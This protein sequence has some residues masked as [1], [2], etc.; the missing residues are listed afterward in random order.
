MDI[1]ER[2]AGKQDGP[3]K[4]I[5]GP[6]NS[7]RFTF[8]HIM[9]HISQQLVNCFHA[10]HILS[11]EKLQIYQKFGALGYDLIL[12]PSFQKNY[13]AKENGPGLVSF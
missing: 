13:N 6:S 12:I 1:G 4:I 5:E 7:Q 2:L 9:A 10:E 11:S 3:S 8:N